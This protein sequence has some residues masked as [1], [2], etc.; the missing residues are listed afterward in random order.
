MSPALILKL[1]RIGK[2]IL[3]H[4]DTIKK[5]AK[6]VAKGVII[7]G[8]VTFTLNWMWGLEQKI[9]KLERNARFDIPEIDGMP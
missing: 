9:I 2:S 1:I 5:Y 7:G 3:K 8:L 4:K 6:P